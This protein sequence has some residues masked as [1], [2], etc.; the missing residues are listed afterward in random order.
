MRG[1]ELN[2]PGPSTGYPGTSTEFTPVVNQVMAGGLLELAEV[3]FT[4]LPRCTSCPQ[5]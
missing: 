3:Q 5:R 4:Y 1:G 2:Y